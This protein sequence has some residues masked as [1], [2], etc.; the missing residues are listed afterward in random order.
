MA[1][2]MMI[3]RNGAGQHLPAIVDRPDMLVR[4][5]KWLVTTQMVYMFNLWLCRVSGLAFYA[6]L[7]PM[8][9]FMTYL[10]LS[11]AFVTLVWVVQTLICALQCVPLAA[12]W[13][14]NVKGWCMGSGTVFVST[15]VL[16]IACDSLILLLPVKIV[17]SLQTTIARKIALLGILCFGVLYASLCP[18]TFVANILPPQR[19]CVRPPSSC[20]RARTTNITSQEHPFSDWSR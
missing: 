17:L 1:L 15:G 10:R 8:P 4:M 9:R 5:Y 6:R 14:K 13:D 3:L 16:T 12:L 18:Y 2:C 19:D 20:L 11:F 7:N